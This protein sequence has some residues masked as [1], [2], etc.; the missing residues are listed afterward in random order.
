MRVLV[1][2]PFSG[3]G[4]L[5]K[6]YRH[7]RNVAVEIKA[8]IKRVNVPKDIIFLDGQSRSDRNRNKAQKRAAIIKK[9][10]VENMK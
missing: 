5:L 9:R 7:Q 8:N 4:F 10:Y 1:V 2:K 3:I 6:I